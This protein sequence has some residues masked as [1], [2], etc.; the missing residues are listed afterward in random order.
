MFAERNKIP[1]ARLGTSIGRRAVNYYRGSGSTLC[2][3]V[4]LARNV[5]NYCL[6]NSIA[7][8][9]WMPQTLIVKPAHVKMTDAC[10]LENESIRS[11]L[12]NKFPGTT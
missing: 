5:F 1:W 10:R 2:R 3:K 12:I 9:E 11:K 6:A 4:G 8:D 7:V